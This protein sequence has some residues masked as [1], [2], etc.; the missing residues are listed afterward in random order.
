MGYVFGAL[1]VV[2][3][4]P[5]LLSNKNDVEGAAFLIVVGIVLFAVGKFI[6][7]KCAAIYQNG[8]TQIKWGEIDFLLWR[9]VRQIFVERETSYGSGLAYKV[10]YNCTFQR[11]NGTWLKLNAIPITAPVIKA[12]QQCAVIANS[13]HKGNITDSQA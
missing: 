1:G 4:L 6:Q 12:L 11:C 13:G 10:R 7:K 9:D 2:L 5:E 8:I 3:L